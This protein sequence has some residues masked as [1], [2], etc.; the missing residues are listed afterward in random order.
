MNSTSRPFPPH[1][2]DHH[3]LPNRDADPHHPMT[4]TPWGYILKGE[5]PL[6]PTDPQE[7]F[8]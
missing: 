4:D 3:N 8:R 6:D 5:N 7:R 1:P 2:E